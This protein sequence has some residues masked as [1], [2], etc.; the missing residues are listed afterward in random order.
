MRVHRF[1]AVLLLLSLAVSACGSSIPAETSPP[2]Q[3]NSPTKPSVEGAT[4]IASATT[5]APTSSPMPTVATLQLEIVQSQAWTDRDGN[6][7]ANVLL[8]N[9]YDFPIE[10]GGRAH[11]N[12]LNSAGEQMRSHRLYFLD[13]ISGGNGFILPGEM[14][15]ANACFTCETTLLPEEWASVEYEVAIQDA[16]ESWDYA[17]D[18]EASV[19]EVSFDGDSPIFWVTGT[20]TNLSGSALD[21]ISVRIIVFDQAGNLVGAAEASTWEVG[22]AATA[23][24]SGY[25]IGLKPEGTVTFDISALGVNY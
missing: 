4:A 1:A 2:S 17:I 13:G 5:A 3:A 24:F 19:G 7:R 25:G 9:P 20:V 18:V 6:V 23:S 11:A 10:P 16:T 14:I 21:R 12:V 22:P 15:A 8:R